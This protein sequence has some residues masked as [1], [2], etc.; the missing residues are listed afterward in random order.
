MDP[1]HAHALARLQTEFCNGTGT[2][3]I[4]TIDANEHG[5]DLRRRAPI[6]AEG[7]YLAGPEPHL[8]RCAR[9]WLGLPTNEAVSQELA[10]RYRRYRQE[11]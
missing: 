11:A 6:N 8:W 3:G 4:V 1:R 9:E 10:A 5:I 7:D 2:L